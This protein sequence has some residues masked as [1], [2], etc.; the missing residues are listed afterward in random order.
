MYSNWLTPSV[1]LEYM[2]IK[3][4]NSDQWYGSTEGYICTHTH[5]VLQN[6]VCNVVT[7]KHRLAVPNAL[8]VCEGGG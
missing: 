8:L 6:I 3:A 7:E 4:L 5:T 2:A 1:S